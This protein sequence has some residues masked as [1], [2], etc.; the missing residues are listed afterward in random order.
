MDVMGHGASTSSDDETIVLVALTAMAS[1]TKAA[2]TR[3][4]GENF[5][6]VVGWY[7]SILVALSFGR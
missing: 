7:R 6:V 1:G 3:T 4:R 2:A 5:M